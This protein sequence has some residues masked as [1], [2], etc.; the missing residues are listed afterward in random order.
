M[1]APDPRL[2]PDSGMAAL[3]ALASHHRLPFDEAGLRHRL[4][5]G[6][7]PVGDR[8]LLRSAKMTGLKARRFAIKTGE[9]LIKAP[10]PSIVGLADGSYRIHLLQCR[11]FQFRREVAGLAE[12]LD[13]GA[14]RAPLF[15]PAA[16]ARA[17]HAL[18]QDL[19]NPDTP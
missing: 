11:T 7:D 15:A 19:L 14:R 3:A 1:N 12:R 9:D 8:D 18:V 6:H 10:R 4:A 17:L 16:E 13:A 2:A 5:L